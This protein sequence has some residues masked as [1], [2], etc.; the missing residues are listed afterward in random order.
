M[1]NKPDEWVTS[2]PQNSKRP[3]GRVVLTMAVVNDAIR[4][5]GISLEALDAK[6][7]VTGVLLRELPVKEL[8]AEAIAE[9]YAVEL[10]HAKTPVR[11]LNWDERD[12]EWRKA[13]L[14]HHARVA[15]L[16]ARRS[17]WYGPAVLAEVAEVYRQAHHLGR[18]P[19]KA[20]ADQLFDG[21]RAAAE[22][23][24]K[25]C[26]AKKISLPKTNLGRPKGS[27]S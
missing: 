12:E 5:V 14:D 21:N 13:Y 10:E 22:R 15:E 1:P 26:R 17:W 9:L 4:C 3:W 19:T 23:A 16:G 18:P 8:E 6:R 2:W 7:A 27:K 11:P 24:V 25:L 20:V